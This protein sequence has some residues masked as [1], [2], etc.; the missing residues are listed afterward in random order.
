M[1]QPLSRVTELRLLL[2]EAPSEKPPGE[3]FRVSGLTGS[4]A[5]RSLRNK[6]DLA[7]LARDCAQRLEQRAQVRSVSSKIGQ[8]L[9]HVANEDGNNVAIHGSSAFTTSGLGIAVSEGFDMNACYESA[10]EVASLL[11]WFNGIWNDGAVVRDAKRE[12]LAQLQEIYSEK[13]PEL[14]YLLVL[15]NIF[16]ESLGEI[17]EDKIIKTRTGIKNTLIWRKLY[18]FQRDGVLGAIDKIEKYNG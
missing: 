3:P 18:R 9:F 2:P 6:L 10:S 16:R 14:I 1:R 4:P 8:N 15:Y 13:S 7:R 5:D 17:E 12:V 11:E